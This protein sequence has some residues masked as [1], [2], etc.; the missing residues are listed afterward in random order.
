MEFSRRL[1]VALGGQYTDQRSV[2]DAWLVGASYDFT[3]VGVPGLS[4]F[5]NYDIPIL[6]QQS[7]VGLWQRLTR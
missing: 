2:G 4:S 7:C 5:I 3:R 6:Q 1:G